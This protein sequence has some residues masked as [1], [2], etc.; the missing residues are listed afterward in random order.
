MNPSPQVLKNA[1]EELNEKYPDSNLNSKTSNGGS[2]RQTITKQNYEKISMKRSR[3]QNISYKDCT[4]ENVAF[5]ASSYHN[6]TFKQTKLSGN[7]FA[8]CNFFNSMFVNKKADDVL[9]TG[10][11]FSQSSFT[12][13]NFK[14]IMFKS[15]GFLQSLFYNCRFDSVKFQ[16]NTLEGSCF[17]SCYLEKIDAGH[18]NVEFIEL[19]N[20]SL[21][22]VV[23]PFYQFAYIIGASDFLNEPSDSISFIAGDKDVPLVDYI[24]QINNLIYY[25]DDKQEYFPVCNLLIAKGKMHEAQEVFLKGI[26]QA[27][28]TLDFRMLRHLCRLAKRHD[29]LDEITVR[30]ANKKIENYLYDDNIPPERINDYIVNT[31]EIRKTLLSGKSDSVTYSFNI[32]T[33]IC[34]KNKKGV[35]YV[36][37][38]STELNDALSQNDFGQLGFQVA[39]SNHSPF[40]IIIDVVCAA[41]ALATI[42][43]LIWSIVEK[44]Q[45]DTS[46]DNQ[47]IPD[48][49]V[50]ANNEIYAKCVDS[51]IERSKEQLLNIKL[52]YSERKMNQ[53]IEQVTQQLKT[54][55]A[56][57]YNKDVMIFKKNNT[58][59]T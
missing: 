59:E 54:D 56:D 6:V 13:C 44:K 27:L 47:T 52:K 30:R 17:N 31:G 48:D 10:N 28:D 35:A 33:N 25:Y 24:R 1:L 23:F 46:S 14:K 8:C 19:L 40:E 34:K 36:N 11:N 55:I 41:G 29:L 18:T 2:V 50:L 20:T 5:S 26:N 38:L 32:R 9:Y 51:Y 43:Q 16:S 4:F 21:K 37:S 53:Y 49:Y 39:V 45:S 57:L 12:T 15:S 3:F 58:D 42:A 22:S 7:S